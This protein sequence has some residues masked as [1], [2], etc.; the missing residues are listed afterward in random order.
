[1]DREDMISIL[2]AFECFLWL[3]E[4]IKGLTDGCGIGTEYLG[5]WDLTLVIQRNCVVKDTDEIMRV[6]KDRELGTDEKYELLM[7]R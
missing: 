5:L 1:M 6:V 7:R 4:A 3:D 2:N